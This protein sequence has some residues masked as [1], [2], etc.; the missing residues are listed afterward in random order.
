MTESRAIAGRIDPNGPKQFD[1][2]LEQFRSMTGVD[3]EKDIIAPSGDE[4]AIYTDP[5]I[6]GTMAFGATLIS[7]PKDP[8]KLDQSLVQLGRA[9]TNLSGIVMAPKGMSI[10]VREMKDGELTIHYFATP[11]LRPSW[12]M[13]N[14]VLYVGLFPQVVSAAVAHAKAPGRKSILENES[15]VAVRKRL[16][17]GDVK[18]TCISYVDLPKTAPGIYPAWLFI[19]GY[20]G[21]ADLFGAPGPAMLVP[22]LNDLLAQLAP[23]GSMSWVDDKGW[24]ASGISPFPGAQLL[25][26]DPSMNVGSTAIM[27]SIMLPAFAK[28]RESSVRVQCA[29]NMKQI[30]LACMLYANDNKGKYPPDLG[31]LLKTQDVTAE[32]FLCPSSKI[33]V[34]AEVKGANVDV[35]AAWVNASASYVYLGAG[36]TTTAPATAQTVLLYENRDNHHGE[37]M[38]LLYAD[39]HVEWKRMPEAEAE[40]ARVHVPGKK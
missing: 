37:G 18:P 13:D 10:P 4:W 40:I 6:A 29:S 8:A 21:F 27:A 30:G 9:V 11:I 2:K 38:N 35:Q 26:S 1:Q 20:A 31:T 22:P 25:A 12:T 15:F 28:A 3:L 34:P 14:G 33:A 7:R 23:A 32:V 36:L 17:G 24:H 5:N 39:G 16:G 19:S